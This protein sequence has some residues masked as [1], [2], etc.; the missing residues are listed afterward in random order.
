[1]KRGGRKEK[2]GGRREKSGGKEKRT[3]EGR[4]VPQYYMGTAQATFAE[5]ALSEVTSP[6]VA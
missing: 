3:R 4:S 5:A 2:R 1:M 6:E